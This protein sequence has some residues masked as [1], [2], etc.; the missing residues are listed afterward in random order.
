M[1]ENGHIFCTK[2][3][4]QL[5]SDAF[6]CTK[7][8][9]PTANAAMDGSAQSNTKNATFT[10]VPIN[11]NIGFKEYVDNYAPQSCRKEI[12]NACIVAYVCIGISAVVSLA[13]SPIG[14]IDVLAFLGLYLGVHIARSKVC[15]IIALVLSG[16]EVLASLVLTGVLGG[17]LWIVAGV[18][19]VVA[20]FK[21]DKHYKYFK[22]SLNNNS[23]FST[24]NDFR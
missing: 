23:S 12:R 6:F 24:P 21:A 19:A 17:W 2:C 14:L 5:K 16:I 11:P 13:F 9:T 18:S 7:C 1:N 8:G 4:T 3:G 20:L 15:A 10:N 22:S